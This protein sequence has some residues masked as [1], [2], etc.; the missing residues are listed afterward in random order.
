MPGEGIPLRVSPLSGDVGRFGSAVAGSAPDGNHPLLVQD[1]AGSL[2][3]HAN[4]QELIERSA[5][6]VLVLDDG[7]HA[8][9]V[10]INHGKGVLREEEGLLVQLKEQQDKINSSAGKGIASKLSGINSGLKSIGNTAKNVSSKISKGLSGSIDKTSSSFG[11][12]IKKA[13]KLVLGIFAIRSAYMA[14]RRASS[15]LASYDKQYGANI[16]YIR[17]AL[18]QAIAP[19]LRYIVSLVGTILG[20]INSIIAAITGINIFSNASADNFKKMKNSAGG[21]A[22]SA[23]EIKK[24][25]AGFDEMNVLTNNS[26]SSGGGRRRSSYSRI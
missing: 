1:L 13:G 22:K 16:E 20:Y 24:Q 25:L 15:E 21:V 6:L 2:R 3:L 5:N 23:K 7:F 8:A 9:A 18:T 17:Y 10:R 26:S 11:N 4:R 12:A 19:I 14:L